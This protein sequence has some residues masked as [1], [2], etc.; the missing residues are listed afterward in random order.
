MAGRRLTRSLTWIVERGAAHR[1]VTSPYDGTEFSA[2]QPF[3]V[4]RL[5]GDRI[6]PEEQDTPLAH[7]LANASLNGVGTVFAS[8][9]PD[10]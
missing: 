6:T 9:R 10:P 2:I 5:G 7:D 4:F 3:A 1:R 8:A